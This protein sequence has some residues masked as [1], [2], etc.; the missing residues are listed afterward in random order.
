M[1]QSLQ[2]QELQAVEGHKKTNSR[3]QFQR[4]RLFANRLEFGSEHGA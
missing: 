2:S 4:P 1:P 3:Y